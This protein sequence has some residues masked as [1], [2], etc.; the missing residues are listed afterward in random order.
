[1]RELRPWNAFDTAGRTAT[2]VR[3]ADV[4]T[5]EIR[6]VDV[7]ATDI[8]TT[9]VRTP[10]VRTADIRS[11]PP[12]PTQR[13]ASSSAGA[14]TVG[15]PLSTL[16]RRVPGA[17]LQSL[18]GTGPA[19]AASMATSSADDARDSLAQ[20]ESGVARAMRD[21]DQGEGSK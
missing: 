21:M 18:Q 7:R 9:D 20:F 19:R 6:A 16:N 12:I 2:D 15:Q 10:D 5:A 14:S 11:V 3:T 1:M 13:A 17:T 8:R 4:R